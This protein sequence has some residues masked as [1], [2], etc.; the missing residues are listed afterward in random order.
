MKCK[1][2]TYSI[3][4]SL[5]FYC[6][7]FK[8]S[9][10]FFQIYAFIPAMLDQIKLEYTKIEALPANTQCFQLDNGKW[11]WIEIIWKYDYDFRVHRLLQIQSS[12]ETLREIKARNF[13]IT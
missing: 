8:F 13:K 4:I 10:I 1:R 12:T 3:H 11:I 5:F 2:L 7:S 6:L 9:T